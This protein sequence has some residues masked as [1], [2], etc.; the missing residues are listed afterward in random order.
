MK[1][2]KRLELKCKLQ[3]GGPSTDDTARIP[4][5][6]KRKK[7]SDEEEKKIRDLKCQSSLLQTG[8]SKKKKPL[9]ECPHCHKMGT[10]LEGDC[11]FNPKNAGKKPACQ[12]GRSDKSN[13]ERT[14][15]LKQAIEI[16]KI[17]AASTSNPRKKSSKAKCKRVR[18]EDEEKACLAAMRQHDAESSDEEESEEDD[19]DEE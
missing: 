3:G 8:S 19:P 18:E 9:H 2:F 13:S 16:G 17:M 6:R 4:K 1:K 12:K 7:N 11:A 10:H 14:F 15:S 5:K